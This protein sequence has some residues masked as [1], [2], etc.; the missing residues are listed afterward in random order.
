MHYRFFLFAFL[1]LGIL[2]SGAFGNEQKAWNDCSW[3]S[4]NGKLIT[5]I[6]TIDPHITFTDPSNILQIGTNHW[7][8]GRGTTQ[9]GTISLI[10]EDGTIYG[11]WQ[12]QGQSVYNI[13]NTWWWAFPGVMIKPGNYTIMDSDKS[14]LSANNYSQN[15]GFAS[16]EYNSLKQ[17]QFQASDRLVIERIDGPDTVVS[18]GKKENIS[19]YW[20]GKPFYPLTLFILPPGM[21]LKTYDWKNVVSQYSYGNFS[22]PL[23]VPEAL[24][25]CFVDN[26][27][28]PYD[29][30]LVNGNGIMSEPYHFSF[31]CPRYYVK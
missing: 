23:Y 16:I 22:Y 21:D 10:H 14:T 27:T 25:C 7:N 3:T 30:V 9:S 19:I 18:C 28:I 29:L 2:I 20:N 17:A 15:I 12:T 24:S 31:N 1:C 6:A 11:P 5:G 13:S 8:E 26:T 4:A